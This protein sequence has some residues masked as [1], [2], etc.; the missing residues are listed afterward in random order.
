MNN[1]QELAY[2]SEKKK[3]LVSGNEFA[4]IW[5]TDQECDILNGNK[6]NFNR[7]AKDLIRAEMVETALNTPYNNWKK[8]RSK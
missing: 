2:T 3:Y 6:E 7:Y 1:D 5:L 4:P 8:G